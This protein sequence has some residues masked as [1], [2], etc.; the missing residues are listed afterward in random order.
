MGVSHQGRPSELAPKVFSPSEFC[1]LQL[2]GLVTILP[3]PSS[4]EFPNSFQVVL[5]SALQSPNP[6]KAGTH[7]PTPTSRVVLLDLGHTLF[8]PQWPSPCSPEPGAGSHPHCAGE[9]LSS[10]ETSL[11]WVPCPT[12]PNTSLEFSPLAAFCLFPKL[13]KLGRT[14]S[15]MPFLWGQVHP[16]ARATPGPSLGFPNLSL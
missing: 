11:T 4:T 10:Q 5:E 15:A 12:P 2:H 9:P 8:C 13:P 16:V 14:S 7:L 1:F 3:T 6:S